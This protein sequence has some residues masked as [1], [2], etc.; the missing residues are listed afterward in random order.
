ML[1]ESHPPADASSKSQIKSLQKFAYNCHLLCIYSH[2][3]PRRKNKII[4]FNPSTEEIVNVVYPQRGE[5]IQSPASILGSDSLLLKYLNPH[6]A[7][8]V[9]VVTDELM[10]DVGNNF[11]KVMQAK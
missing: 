3:L 9:T 11:Y 6:L 7:V 8:V 2:L 4:T 1:D 5:V 10:A